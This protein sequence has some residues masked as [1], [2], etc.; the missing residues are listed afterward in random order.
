MS[1]Q[2]SKKM[3]KQLILLVCVG[4][5]M[6]G[7]C[8]ALV[9]LY[10]VFCKV[11]GL[12]GKTADQAQSASVEVDKSRII[13]V[14]LQ[15]TLNGSLPDSASEF[16]PKT[17]KFH[18]HP[19]ESIHTTYWVKNLKSSPVVVQAIP[20][21]S[22]GLAAKHVMKMECFCFQHQGLEAHEGKEMP[23]V[24]TLAPNLPKKINTVT[25]AYTLFDVTP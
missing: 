4:L 16:F 19:G 18:I 5:G 23:L 12:N 13:T 10:S 7:F 14:E 20:S 11:T 3:H 25:L 2:P 21:V 17:K 15:A 8:F 9:P 22:P 24:F 1:R 6:F